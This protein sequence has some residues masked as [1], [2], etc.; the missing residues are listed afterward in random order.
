MSP[1]A[2]F[3]TPLT[4]VDKHLDHFCCRKTEINLSPERF[5]PSQILDADHH[6]DDNNDLLYVVDI[7]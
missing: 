3:S 5:H 1:N 6:D 2:S 4:Q 7:G